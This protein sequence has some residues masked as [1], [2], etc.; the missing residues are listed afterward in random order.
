MMESLHQKPCKILALSSN[1]ENKK[2][3]KDKDVL[4]LPLVDM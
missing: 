2:K 3:R 4:G 1:E